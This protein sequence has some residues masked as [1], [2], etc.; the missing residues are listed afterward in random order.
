MGVSKKRAGPVPRA[1][2]LAGCPSWLSCA[3]S[4]ACSGGQQKT[5]DLLDALCPSARRLRHFF[6]RIAPRRSPAPPCPG[7]SAPGLRLMVARNN[8]NEEPIGE[9]MRCDQRALRRGDRPM[10]RSIRPTRA[11]FAEGEGL[12]RPVRSQGTDNQLKGLLAMGSI[13]FRLARIS[14]RDHSPRS[15]T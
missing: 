12:K 2:S 4:S 13:H 15:I 9:P 8:E 6:A 3:Q 11:K 10:L 7:P 5:R 14:P 1:A